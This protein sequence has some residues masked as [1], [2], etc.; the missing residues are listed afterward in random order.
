MPHTTG[1]LLVRNGPDSN[2]ADFARVVLNFYFPQTFRRSIFPDAGMTTPKQIAWRLVR[3]GRK[4]P[5]AQVQV[6]EIPQVP[7]YRRLSHANKSIDESLLTTVYA[8]PITIV[9]PWLA[10]GLLVD[11]IVRGRYH[12]V[13]KHPEV[14][15]P[16]SI[17]ELTATGAA[18][19]NRP[20]AGTQATRDVS[21]GLPPMGRAAGTQSRLD[22]IKAEQ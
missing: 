11:Y 12:I 20:I 8:I 22:E 16:D 7:G 3:Y 18:N 21:A 10:G 13:P 5:D 4:H 6:Y 15:G 19:Q 9:N 2:C 17:A 1:T 14:A